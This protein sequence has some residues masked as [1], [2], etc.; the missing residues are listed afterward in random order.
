[1]A[2]L[3]HRLLLLSLAPAAAVAATTA[4]HNASLHR[5]GQHH[6]THHFADE[7]E[8]CCT[9]E[10]DD[11]RYDLSALRKLSNSKVAWTA[12]SGID[13]S[14][15]GPTHHYFFNICDNVSVDAKDLPKECRD[16]AQAH[17][18]PGYVTHRGQCTWLGMLGKHKWR[19][20]DGDKPEKGVELIYN[21]GPPC[22]S[23]LGSKH[24]RHVRF[25]FVCAS[26][27]GEADDGPM[28]VIEQPQRCQT[29]VIWPTFHAC[30]RFSARGHARRVTSFLLMVAVV[31]L[32]ARTAHRAILYGARG[33]DA[34]PH[35]LGAALRSL[36]V[37]AGC[38]DARPG[39]HHPDPFGPSAGL[40]KRDACKEERD[41]HRPGDPGAGPSAS[42]LV[43]RV[44]GAA[45]GAVAGAAAALRGA[46][47]GPD[48]L[49][50]RD[51]GDAPRWRDGSARGS[52]AFAQGG[53]RRRSAAAG[54]SDTFPDA[55]GDALGAGRG[56][57]ALAS[58]LRSALAG[59][60]DAGAA[61]SKAGKAL[62]D[63]DV[64]DDG[65]LSDPG[66]GPLLALAE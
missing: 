29:E 62:V 51:A 50:E 2:P 24:T 66:D 21:G 3:V 8:G 42:A 5:E 25:H 17:P 10:F 35:G 43:R 39:H 18:S 38:A 61:E 16:L 46:S 26:A 4:G 7:P 49:L 54:G 33:W 55:K 40:A 37:R 28:A 53:A 12:T 57:D 45:A 60:G 32:A 52:T 6:H 9:H 63:V 23:R 30:P 47:G 19:V 31:Y 15:G 14:D 44:A 64:A 48:A 13:P 58:G 22:T 1:M 41:D 34:L 11:Y 65:S 59:G 27:H 56:M 36:L 20:F